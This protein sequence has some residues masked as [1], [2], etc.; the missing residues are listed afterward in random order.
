M[1][2]L[3]VEAQLR[4]FNGDFVKGIH[5]SN[6]DKEFCEACVESKAHQL[7]FPKHSET[8]SQHKLELVHSDVI[9]PMPESIGG[10]KYALSFV[11]DYTHFV[12]TYSISKK[13]GVFQTFKIWLELVEYQSNHPLKVV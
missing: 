8:K 12:R 7:P 10:T 1:G 5:L 6:R 11:D 4:M 3:G 2:H 9:S 13:S